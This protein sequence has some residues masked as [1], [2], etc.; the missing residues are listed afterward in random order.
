[1]RSIL[2]ATARCASHR[3]TTK[4]SQR[5]SQSWRRGWGRRWDSVCSMHSTPYPSSV[6]FPLLSC[7]AVLTESTESSGCGCFSSAWKAFSTPHSVRVYLWMWRHHRVRPRQKKDVED[8]SGRGQ[9]SPS[10]LRHSLCHRRDRCRVYALHST[11]NYVYNAI[12][13][14]SSNQV[15]WIRRSIRRIRPESNFHWRIF[16][17]NPP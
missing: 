12:C 10:E 13:G 1:M 8:A 5:I 7:R 14:I 3:S 4:T 15:A 6:S 11:I 16:W 17:I 2:A 9:L